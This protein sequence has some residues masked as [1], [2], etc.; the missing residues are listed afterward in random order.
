MLGALKRIFGREEPR[1]LVAA[2]PDG[3]VRRAKLRGV[4]RAHDLDDGAPLISEILVFDAR[5]HW[6]FVFA[7]R[8]AL[9]LPFE[10]SLRAAKKASEQSAPDWPIE[11]VTRVANAIGDDAESFRSPPTSSRRE[12]TTSA[13]WSSGSTRPSRA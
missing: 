4:E 2:F 9:G 12:A 10:L 11:P 8:G 6:L 1:A 7:G 3:P 13:H 5:T